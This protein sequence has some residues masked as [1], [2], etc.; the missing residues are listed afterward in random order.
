MAKKKTI[1]VDENIEK[2]INYLVNAYIQIRQAMLEVNAKVDKYAISAVF[3]YLCKEQ[4]KLEGVDWGSLRTRFCDNV[5]KKIGHR[6]DDNQI[7]AYRI[8]AETIG[9]YNICNVDGGK[10]E[11]L[12]LK[13]IEKGM[14]KNRRKDRRRFP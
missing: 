12:E 13:K 7:N 6:P 14:R 1:T 2:K 3:S 11:I 10:Y 8:L 9:G 4:W 5:E